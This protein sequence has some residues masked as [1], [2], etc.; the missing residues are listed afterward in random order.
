MLPM[1]CSRSCKIIEDFSTF[2]HWVTIHY[3]RAHTIDHYLGD[4]I[5]AGKDARTCQYLMTVFQT[6]CDDIG[7]PIAEEKSEGL[8]TC[9]TFWGL[10]IDT[11]N[12]LVKIPDA[13]CSELQDLLH[14]LI[15]KRKTTLKQLLSVI[16]KLKFLL[17]KL[18][19][20]VGQ[21]CGFYIMQQWVF[22]N[23]TIM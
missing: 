22:Q 12:M 7:V 9:M 2:L 19:D 20:P 10:G 3:A 13:K 15:R 21:S 5:F 8:F 4:L 1:G 11:I 18:S 6:I 23:S 17:Q 14:Q 16:G